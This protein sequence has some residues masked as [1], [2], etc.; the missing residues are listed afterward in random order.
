MSENTARELLRKINATGLLYKHNLELDA[1]VCN[2]LARPE[3][4][5]RSILDPSVYDET[6][7][8]RNPEPSGET[9]LTDEA[10]DHTMRFS[11]RHQRLRDLCRSLERRLRE[12]EGEADLMRRAIAWANNSLYGSHGFF[13]S[14]CGDKVPH[15]HHLDTPIEALKAYG[16]AQWH[17]AE[18]AERRP[19]LADELRAKGY[20]E[21]GQEPNLPI[22]ATERRRPSAQ[23]VSAGWRYRDKHTGIVTLTEQP[24]DRV[25]M[26]D[27][28]EATELFARDPLDLS[29]VG[30]KDK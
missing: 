3:P 12:A 11:G 18:A 6:D 2:F 8:H 14:D 20:K 9:P 30:G 10:D 25:L 21:H 28:Y 7:Q 16:N 4:D 1:E 22:G 17:R 26:L 27:Q 19:S 15:E 29:T 23:M 13:L 24:P 5:A